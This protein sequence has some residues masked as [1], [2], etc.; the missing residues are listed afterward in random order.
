MQLKPTMRHATQSNGTAIVV[1]PLRSDSNELQILKRLHS[2][3]SPFNHTIPLLG[4]IELDPWTFTLFPEGTPLDQGLRRGKFRSEFLGFSR[5]LIDGVGFLHCHGIAHLDIKPQNIVILRNQLL[6]IDFDISVNISGPD[7]LINRYCGTRD[8]MAPEIGGQDGPRFWYSPVRADLWSCGK[9]LRY[10]ANEIKGANEENPF[11]ALTSQLLHRNP[12]LR[13]QLYPV[14]LK[15][16]QD[17]LPRDV[18]RL[19][20]GT[21]HT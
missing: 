20:N 19:A 3:N 5:Q 18:K 2:I 14:T 4:A 8:W 21:V 7:T 9:V 6:I 13:P 15:R 1:K 10:L 11:G 17:F 12:L 16:K